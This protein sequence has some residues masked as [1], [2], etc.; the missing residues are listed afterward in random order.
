MEHR[1]SA[2]VTLGGE[3]HAADAVVKMHTSAVDAFGSPD[4]GPIGSGFVSSVWVLTEAWSSISRY[5]SY[6]RSGLC[7]Y[8]FLS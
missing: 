7:R 8:S 4:T 1:N 3:V 6:T 5:L 2:V